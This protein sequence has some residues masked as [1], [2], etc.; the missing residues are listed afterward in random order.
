MSTEFQIPSNPQEFR[1][2]IE[3]KEK[4]HHQ[5]ELMA[6]SL[7]ESK[8]LVEIDPKDQALSIENIT[9]YFPKQKLPF[10]HN[11]S[12]QLRYDERIAL[13][14]ASGS[15]KTTIL[16]IVAGIEGPVSGRIILNQKDISR[17]PPEKR[18]IGIIFQDYALFPHMTVKD[19]IGFGVSDKSEKNSKIFEM[20]ELLRISEHLPKYPNQLSGGQQQRVAIARALAAEPSILLLDEPFSNLDADLRS[21]VRLEIAKLLE[22]RRV[23]AILVTHDTHDALSFADRVIRIEAGKILT[24]TQEGSEKS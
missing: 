2:Y 3:L 24:P 23:P 15:G 21:S 5:I 13:L 7:L 9:F 1:K 22:V 6:T 12:F 11:A 4:E 18:K 19:N 16:R 10:I 14:G 17:L 8:T 20:A